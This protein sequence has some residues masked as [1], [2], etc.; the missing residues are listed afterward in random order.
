MSW[1]RSGVPALRGAAGRIA[2]IFFAAAVIVGLIT[3]LGV[4]DD[5][6][7]D[8]LPKD[9]IAY[10][11]KALSAAIVL[12]VANIAATFI[13][14]GLERSLGHVSPTVRR[15]VP[16]IVRGAI[17]FMGGL[18]AG[19]ARCRHPDPHPR[20]VSGV[21]RCGSHHRSGRLFRQRARG[22]G[23]RGQPCAATRSTSATASTPSSRGARSSSSTV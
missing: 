3:A 18:I 20:G 14:A 9:F 13:V 5:Q 6:A 10:V 16:P 4:V 15:R 19:P 21:L 17:L 1:P 12:I 23:G 22:V 8:D 7:V 11:P 2:S